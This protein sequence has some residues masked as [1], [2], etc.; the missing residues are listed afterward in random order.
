V[1]AVTPVHGPQ[2]VV[3]IIDQFLSKLEELGLTVTLRAAEKLRALRKELASLPAGA[4]LG[5]SNTSRISVIMRE[6]WPTLEAESGGTVAYIISERRFP[7]EKLIANVGGL[8]AKDAFQGIPMFAQQDFSEAGKCL[9]F[10]RATSAAFHML[11]G[12]ESL[13]RHYYCKKVRN[14]RAPLMW[15]PIVDSMRKYPRRFP[16][17]L[18]N[19]LDHIRISFRNPT[20]HPEKVFDIDEAQDLFA[21]CID[22]SNRMT[23][24]LQ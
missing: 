23:K 10:E 15:G 6:L 7:I 24:E 5:E 16:L 22:V 18:I 11:R 17:P 12:T 14:K 1:N 19:Q 20:A 9:A 4:T 2:K 8:F 21:I 13:L 3:S